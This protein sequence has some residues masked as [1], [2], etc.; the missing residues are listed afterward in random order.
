LV[1]SDVYGPMSEA[2]CS[3]FHY[4]LT[5][6]HGNTRKTF[7]YFLRSKGEVLS[8]TEQFKALENE[9]RKTLKAER[10]DNG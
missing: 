1:H 5:L 3:G 8:N 4:F 10:T 6:I 9:N 2:S 7:V